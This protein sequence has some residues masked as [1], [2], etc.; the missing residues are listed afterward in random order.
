MATNVVAVNIYQI[1]QT[2]MVRDSP[3]RIAFPSTGVLLKSCADSPD[4]SLSS[5]YNVYSVI[6][7]PTNGAANTNG[8]WYYA[9]ETLTQLIALFNA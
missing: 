5:G 8:N 4:R 1:N 2:V 7:V 3:Q 9:A 6:I